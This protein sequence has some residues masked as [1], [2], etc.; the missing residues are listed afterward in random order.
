[1]ISPVRGGLA[2]PVATRDVRADEKR[3]SID[4]RPSHRSSS[5]RRSS[6]AKPEPVVDRDADIAGRSVERV[7][8]GRPGRARRPKGCGEDFP[9][10]VHQ[11]T[12]RRREHGPILWP[13][14]AAAHFSGWRGM[15]SMAR[16]ARGTRMVNS[17]QD[18]LEKLL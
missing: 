7:C 1:M 5:K 15:R 17:L 11:G 3:H 12:L 8:D 6:P 10:V 18:I 9:S 14:R 4:S 2:R 16:E 13:K